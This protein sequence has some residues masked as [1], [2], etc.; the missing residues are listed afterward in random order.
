MKVG[1]GVPPNQYGQQYA[2]PAV[3]IPHS[4]SQPEPYHYVQGEA[5][6][7]KYLQSLKPSMDLRFDAPQHEEV[8]QAM[9]EIMGPLRSVWMPALFD[10]LNPVS[11]ARFSNRKL[12]LS[13]D[14]GTEEQAWGTARV[15]LDK[16]SAMLKESGGPYIMGKQGAFTRPLLERHLTLRPLGQSHSPTLWLSLR[17]SSS[18]WPI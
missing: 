5:E 13:R 9:G 11:Q 12:N 1:S 16:L 14:Q 2:V 4:D 18:E 10:L 3:A 15:G 17:C 6:V 8:N 7:P